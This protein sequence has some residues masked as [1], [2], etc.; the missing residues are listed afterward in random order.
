VVARAEA[1]GDPA[2]KARALVFMGIAT[3]SS[4]DHRGALESLSRAE[5]LRDAL[6]PDGRL[7]LDGIRAQELL[8]VGDMK[9]GLALAEA[10]ITGRA[11]AGNYANAA[12]L[13]LDIGALLV[14][15]QADGAGKWLVAH[16]PITQH[17]GVEAEL[18]RQSLLARTIFGKPS[19]I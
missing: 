19:R 6:T 17:A 3:S 1:A 9:A 2:L 14:A 11:A 18:Q 5:T 15:M 12:T 7:Q 16:Q 4:G 8:R 13:V 10:V